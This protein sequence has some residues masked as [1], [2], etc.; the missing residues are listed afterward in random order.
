MDLLTASLIICLLFYLLVIYFMV[1]LK[2]R[3]AMTG[4]LVGQGGTINNDTGLLLH[5]SGD[6]CIRFY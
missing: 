5:L 4:T 3:P 2:P 6:I 1:L